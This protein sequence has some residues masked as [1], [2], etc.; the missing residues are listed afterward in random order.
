MVRPGRLPPA[1][2]GPL[3]AGI[4]E[5][6]CPVLAADARAGALRLR[7]DLEPLRALAPRRVSPAAAASA[8][9]ATAPLVREGDSVAVNGCCLTVAALSGDAASFD[10]V[11][12]TL[13]CTNL[14]AL[15]AGAPANIERSL[16]YGDPLDGH[17]VSG[18]VERTGRVLS[19]DDRPGDRRLSVSCGADFAS[20]TLLKG[21]VAIDGVSLTV[22]ELHHDR[23]AVVLVPQTLQRTTLSIRTPGDR[24]NLEAD[25]LGQWVLRSL[26]ARRG[27]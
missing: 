1:L 26:T 19:V 7:I 9:A 6:R 23:L 20:R 10:V 22:A 27:D 8:S 17:L 2:G 16:C 14:G 24:V 3:L 21:S 4:I 12:E 13:R 15:L 18:H 25:L 5:A 11:E